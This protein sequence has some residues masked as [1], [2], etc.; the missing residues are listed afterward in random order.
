MITGNRR[1]HG[2]IY[3]EEDHTVAFIVKKPFK[4]QPAPPS[5]YQ[6]KPES[7]KV[8]ESEGFAYDSDADERL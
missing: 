5:R 4:L 6:I 3:L 8:F 2:A 7:E 1:K